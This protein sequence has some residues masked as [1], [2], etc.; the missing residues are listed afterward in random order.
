VLEVESECG[1]VAFLMERAAMVT[2]LW[3]TLKKVQADE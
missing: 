1:S 2:G 3:G